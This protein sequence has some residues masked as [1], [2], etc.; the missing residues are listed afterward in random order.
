MLIQVYRVLTEDGYI[1]FR[2]QQAA[3]DFAAGREIQE[4]ERELPNG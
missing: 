1:E 4:L 2:D 3:V